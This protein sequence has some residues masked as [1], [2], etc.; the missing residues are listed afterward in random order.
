MGFARRRLVWRAVERGKHPHPLGFTK[1]ASMQ[2]E[3]T[4]E[5]RAELRRLAESRG[6]LHWPRLIA[7]LNDIDKLLN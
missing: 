7:L 2:L 1:P 6:V 3:T 4:A 5:Q